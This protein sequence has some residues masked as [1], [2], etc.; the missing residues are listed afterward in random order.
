MVA[1]ARPGSGR[2][3]ERPVGARCLLAPERDGAHDEASERGD[4]QGGPYPVRQRLVEEHEPGHDRDRVR[5]HGRRAGGGQRVALLVCRLQHTGPG[6]VGDDERDERNEPQPA[7]ADKLRGDVTVGEQQASRETERRGAAEARRYGDQERRAATAHRMTMP[8]TAGWLSDA[9]VP[10]RESASSVSP[11]SAR[12]TANCSR[13]ASR[14]G[15]P[16]AVANARTATPDAVTDWTSASGARRRA[17]TYM[18]QP[19]LSV[20]NAVSQ[21]RSRSRNS[22]DRNGRRGESGGSVAA[23]S[24]S[25]GGRVWVRSA[26]TNAS[27]SPIHACGG[28]LRTLSP[29]SARH[30]G[31]PARSRSYSAC[32]VD[33][34][35]E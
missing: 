30:A 35:S 21:R 13:R 15:C 25:G 7:I 18:S 27:A 32:V 9:F 3:Y 8:T 4:L 14:D 11:A 29:R 10:T 31:S 5:H 23:A 1:G 24:G 16:P 34:R 12:T 33:A 26:E 17:A 2:R 28:I 22:T 20:P 6:A 19:A